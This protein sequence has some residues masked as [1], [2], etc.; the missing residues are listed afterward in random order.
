MHVYA[1]NTDTLHLANKYAHFYPDS[2][3]THLVKPKINF[4][5][6]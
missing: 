4:T 1:T 6:S 5:W 2:H 3:N